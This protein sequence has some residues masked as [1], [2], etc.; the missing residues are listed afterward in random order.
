MT[1]IDVIDSQAS[2]TMISDN[3]CQR[4]ISL[5]AGTRDGGCE[6]LCKVHKVPMVYCGQYS[7]MLE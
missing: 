2:S 5:D 1:M 7:R 4:S 6:H 3:A